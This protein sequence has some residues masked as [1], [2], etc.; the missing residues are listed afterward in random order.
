MMSSS[1]LETLSCERDIH[2]P[3]LN[4]K[5][6]REIFSNL[7]GNRANLFF[8]KYWEK[9]PVYFTA[10]KGNNPNPSANIINEDVFSRRKLLEIVDT[11][12]LAIEINLSAVKYINKSR[13]S[14]SFNSDIASKKEVEKAFKELYT[15]QFFQPQRFSDELHCINAGFEHIFGSLAGASAYLTPADTQGLAPHHD[16]VDV[17]VLQV[18]LTLTQPLTLTVAF[19]CSF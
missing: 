15:I 17:F 16:D 19:L 13:Q 3:S 9:R 10:N 14:R 1:F 5:D 7:T 11:T 6:Y 18:T 2:S 8:E 4:P 12:D